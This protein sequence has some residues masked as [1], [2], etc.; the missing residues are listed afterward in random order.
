VGRTPSF[1][2]PVQPLD[3][4]QDG[5]FEKFRAAVFTPANRVAAAAHSRQTARHRAGGGR[6][7]GKED[8]H[9]KRHYGKKDK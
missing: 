6:G 1:Q 4:A 9:R 3:F 8:D 7:P 2:E 5:L